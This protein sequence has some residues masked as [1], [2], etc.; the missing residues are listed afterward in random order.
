LGGQL[1]FQFWYMRKIIREA[2]RDEVLWGYGQGMA[3]VE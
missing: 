3:P 2:L 1:I